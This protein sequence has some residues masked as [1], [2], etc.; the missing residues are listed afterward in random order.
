MVRITEDF[1]ATNV[2]HNP[3]PPLPQAPQTHFR[4]ISFLLGQ[5]PL[6]CNTASLLTVDC[7][8]KLFCNQMDSHPSVELSQTLQAR[9]SFA[10]LT[11]LW[12]S[13]VDGCGG[14]VPGCVGG[15]AGTPWSAGHHWT[16][17]P[18]PGPPPPLQ[19]P[20]PWSPPPAYECQ[21]SGSCVCPGHTTAICQEGG[22]GLRGGRAD[23]GVMNVMCRRHA[24]V[25][26]MLKRS[27]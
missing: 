22:A 6:P 7:Q 21:L 20:P 11:V 19:T 8:Q 12:W 24:G 1:N 2:L 14:G 5:S 4:S 17:R 18:R 3:P 27:V 23:V 9:A 25:K 15:R 26:P 10:S 16:G 13:K